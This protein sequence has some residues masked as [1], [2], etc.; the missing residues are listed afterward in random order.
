MGLQIYVWDRDVSPEFSE[1]FDNDK[2]LIVV[3][4]SLESARTIA[5]AKL[6]EAIYENHLKMGYAEDTAL[7]WTDKFVEVWARIINN[8]TPHINPLEGFTY[9]YE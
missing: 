5:I 2:S 6:R 3:T 4:T 9:Y 7:R 1:A 8:T